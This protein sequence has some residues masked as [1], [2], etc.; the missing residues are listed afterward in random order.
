MHNDMKANSFTG[1]IAVP[2]IIL[3]VLLFVLYI[4]LW[5]GYSAQVLDGWLVSLLGAFL[6][7][8]MFTLLHEACHGNI[9]GGHQQLQTIETAIGW[10]ASATLFFPYSAFVVIHLHHHAHTNDPEKD[11]DGYVNGNGV[12]SIFL[13]CSTLV[14]HYYVAS[15]N[16]KNSMDGSIR[17][18]R[19]HSLLFIVIILAITIT[20]IV[21]GL[22]WAFFYVF[23]LP[24]LIAA[25]FLGFTFDWLPHYP[26]DNMG[27]Y[28]NTRIVTVPGLE[29]LLLFQS[30][31]HIHH[32]YP[33]IPFYKYKLKYKTIESELRNK[34]TPIEGFSSNDAPLF[35][36]K[37]TYQDIAMGQTWHYALEILAIIYL[38]ENAIEVQFKNLDNIP[39]VYI[40]G[41]YVVLSM[42]VEGETISRCYSICSNPNEGSL[43][44]GIKRV[45]NGK[46]SN[47]LANR[48]VIGSK[49]NVKGPFGEF[50]FQKNN[51]NHQ[52]VNKNKVNHIFIAGGSGITPMLSMLQK[53]LDDGESGLTLIYGCRSDK[54]A[55][56]QET[57]EALSAKYAAQ[58]TLNITYELLTAN[59]Q[60]E[61]LKEHCN[62][63]F[64]YLCGPAP[65]MEASKEAL[66]HKGVSISNII[67][68]EFGTT[69]EV[70]IGAE[71]SVNLENESFDSY[72][73][74]TI[75]EASMRQNIPLPYAC[76]MGQCGTC[77]VKLVSGKVK[78][79][80]G[81]QTALL[82]NE[83]EQ[84]YILTCMCSPKTPLNIKK[85]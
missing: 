49:I 62:S 12:F 68:E 50:K 69:K 70:L 46:L 43:K 80:N 21:N 64:Y 57:L 7:Y 41:Q 37:N 19:A 9:S 65:M 83:K 56:F 73:S 53:E 6:A 4:A 15:F 58:F 31:H 36:A 79:K 16:T 72:E 45:P 60:A 17:N 26:H 28:H 47:A 30:Y 48:L 67:L 63:S 38:T 84:G 51:N 82:E 10:I 61:I 8:G 75:L 35:N 32:L 59:Y 81:P 52:S 14:G 33:R 74:E 76:G 85:K 22:G 54:D 18:T 55:M 29:F 2:T 71:H 77:K 20:L 3:F 1:H 11:P 23:L 5:L 27:K 39:F 44:I 25:T 13:R 34:K 24:A 66:S 42:E 40:A 78:W